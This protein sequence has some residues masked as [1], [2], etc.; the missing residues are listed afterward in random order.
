VQHGSP[1]ALQQNVGG[2]LPENPPSHELLPEDPPLD[3][4]PEDPPLDAPLLEE[5]PLDEPPLDEPLPEDAAP[6][7]RPLD[8]LLPEDVL[9]EDPP[10]LDEPLPE[11]LLVAA[12]LPL[13][14]DDESPPDNKVPPPHAEAKAP[15]A[16]TISRSRHSQFA[17]ACVVAS[18]VPFASPAPAARRRAN[19]CHGRADLSYSILARVVTSN[20]LDTPRQRS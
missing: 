10:P 12:S 13:W 8:E 15:P 6:E 18:S 20:L 19:V 7:D 16:S 9:P 2:P 17:M 5:A 11:E 1:F 14:L 4:L 3:A